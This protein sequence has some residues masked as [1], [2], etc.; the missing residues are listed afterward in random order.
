MESPS[1][2]LR[3]EAKPYIPLPPTFVRPPPI[4]QLPPP[5]FFPPTALC[6]YQAP[7]PQAMRG[8]SGCWGTPLGPGAVGMPLTPAPHGAIAMPATGT[9]GVAVTARAV[10]QAHVVPDKQQQPSGSVTRAAGRAP[11]ARARPRQHLDVPPRMQR[12]ARHGAPAAC[13]AAKA[14]GAVTGDAASENEPSPRSVL[15]SAT[16]TSPPITP[17][18]TSLPVPCSP[19]ATA[20]LAAPEELPPHHSVELGAASKPAGPGKQ[21]FLR[22]CRRAAQSAPRGGAVRRIAPRL[23]FDPSSKRTSLMI[24]DIPNDFSRRRMMSI[25]DEHCFIENQRIPDGGVKSEYDFLYVPMDFRTL[26]NKGYAFV[27]MT[28]PE[29]ARRLWE[30]LHSHRWEVRRCGKTCAVD[31]AATQGLDNLLDR[32]SGSSFCCAT[33][34]FLPARFE[35]P[36]DGTRPAVSVI[37]VLGRLIRRHS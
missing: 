8:F 23:M 33:E 4:A 20:A 5:G 27:N 35:P 36:R 32:F 31:Y 14:A 34:E 6:P 37:H 1:Q 10:P 30:H 9:P 15:Y 3:A 21:K 19:P 25:I 11:G 16:S 26:A 17:T 13:R 12:A 28:S 2:A 7:P 29:A 22:G 18:T 24:R